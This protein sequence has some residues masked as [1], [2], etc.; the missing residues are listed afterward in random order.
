MMPIKMLSTT[1][2]GWMVFFSSVCTVGQSVQGDSLNVLVYVDGNA[3]QDIDIATTDVINANVLSQTFLNHNVMG[4]ISNGLEP[5]YFSDLMQ[6]KREL[7]VLLRQDVPYQLEQ[8]WKD[9]LQFISEIA[10]AIDMV[11]I[12]TSQKQYNSSNKF[13]MHLSNMMQISFLEESNVR[14]N[15]QIHV[16]GSHKDKIE[17]GEYVSIYYHGN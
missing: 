7:N 3:L 8:F 4:V 14:S 6:L 12:V 17:V 11:L 5:I 13:Y 16:L 15:N 1:L 9:D 2:F 10:D